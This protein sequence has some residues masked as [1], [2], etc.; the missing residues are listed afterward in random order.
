MITLQEIL[1]IKT[2]LFKNS[3]VKLVRHKDNRAEYRELIK[4]RNELLNYQK[5]QGKHVFKDCD[6]IISF[7][8]QERK[9]QSFLVFSK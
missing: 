9:N 8:G 5:E 2:N 3:K 1:N 7:I 6:Y 4:D